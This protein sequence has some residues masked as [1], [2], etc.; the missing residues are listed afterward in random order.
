MGKRELLIAA[1]FIV[2]GALAYSFTAAPPKEGERGF[3][4]RDI[5]SHIRREMRSD[6]SSA[7]F[8]HT[9]T[10]AVA[11]GIE[12]V[13]FNTGRSVPITVQGEDRRDIAYELA[14]QSTG[15]DPAAALDYAK[16]VTLKIDDLGSQLT[17]EVERPPEGRQTVALT[18]KVPARLAVRTESVGR[19]RVQSVSA[20]H[21]GMVSGETIAEAI[22]GEVTG[23]HRSGELTVTGAGSVNLILVGSRAT[24]RGVERG[25]TLNA[26]SGECEVA[27]SRGRLAFTGTS[28]RLQVSGVDGAIEIGGDGGQIRIDRPLRETRIDIRRAIVEVTLAAAVPLTILTSDEVIRLVLDGPPPVDV[29]AIASNGNVDAADFGLTPEKTDRA[30]RL[31]HAFGA[32]TAR[33]ILRNSHADIVLAKVK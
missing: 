11:A 15:P 17:L 16:R 22:R 20:V 8:T 33:V 21:M 4:L 23:T 12:E 19:M 13:R 6:S 27:D 25:L 14:V 29:D 28:A 1:A 9:G 24:F 26:R 10:I 7:E 5:F 18:M 30:T 3:S 2:V 32:K 31:S